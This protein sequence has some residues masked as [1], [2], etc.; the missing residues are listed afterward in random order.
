MYLGKMVEIGSGED[1]FRT[2]QHPYTKALLASLPR[3]DHKRARRVLG[4]EIPS[5]AK[6]PEGC[7]FH[8]RCPEVEPRCRSEEPE[9]RTVGGK[10]QTACHLV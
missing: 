10:R 1:L 7:R 2:P 5:A 9:L 3:A 8:T 4:G 6:P